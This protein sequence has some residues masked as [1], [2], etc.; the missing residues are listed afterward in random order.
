MIRINLLPVRESKKVEAVKRELA[1]GGLAGILVAAACAVLFVILQSQVNGLK[2][3]NKQLEDDIANLKSIVARV[4]EIDELK[5][6][7]QK[8][9]H[10]IGQLKR[11][12]AGPVHMLDELSNAT[13]EKLSLL[14][15][16]ESSGRLTIR[17]FAVS[18]EVISQFLSNMEASEW[19]DE[20]YLIEI[21]QEDK[22]GYKVKEFSVTARLSVPGNKASDDEAS[23]TVKN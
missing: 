1:L 11:N 14:E 12:K 10:V 18:N 20:V 23:K 2:A 16:E 22:G 19:F 3:Q 17:G 15:L 13:P 21:D 6:E 9:L 8:K 5:Q 4:D 7:L